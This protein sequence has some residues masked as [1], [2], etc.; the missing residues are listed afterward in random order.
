MR[1]SNSVALLASIVLPL[2]GGLARAESKTPMEAQ[3]AAPAKALDLFPPWQHGE[4]S[5]VVTRGLDLTIH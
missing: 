4:N 1:R 5:D 2:L 3:Q